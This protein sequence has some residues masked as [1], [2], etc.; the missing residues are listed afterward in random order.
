[1][2]HYNNKNYTN[3][4]RF[5]A[6]CHFEYSKGSL[7]VCILPSDEFVNPT[8]F[9]L[10]NPDAHKLSLILSYLHVIELFSIEQM[11]FECLINGNWLFEDWPEFAMLELF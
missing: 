7:A 10:I 1:M 6:A 11:E 4:Q 5:K 3:N 9:W 8:D 2:T